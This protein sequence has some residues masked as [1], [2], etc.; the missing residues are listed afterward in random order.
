MG[1]GHGITDSPL[2]NEDLA[3]VSAANRSWSLWNIAALWVGMA[4]CIP[5][6]TLAAGLIS[7]G[8]SWKQAL[9]TIALGNLI[10][11]LPMMLN[12]HAGTRYGI[13]FPVLLRASFGTVGAN[14][15]AMMRALV[16]CG[17]FGIQTWIGGSAIYTLTL[18]ILGNEPA[19]PAQMLP[20]L[21]LSWGQLFGFLAFWA[22][23]IAVIV[24]G[25]DT[26]KRLETFAAPFLLLI[27]A[28]LLIWGIR[29]AGGLDVVLAADTVARV[30]GEL[31][32]GF[33]FWRAFWPNLTAMVGFWAT[34]SLN[35][36]DFS[37]YARSQ[38]DQMLGQLI[39]LPTTMAFYSFIGIAVTCA[40][41]VIFG[42]AIWDPVQLLG[43]FDNKLTVAFALFA[44][45]V[46]TL[47]TNIAANV[48]SPAN[49]FANLRPRSISFRRG[50]LITGTI[51]ILIMPWKL[52][53]DLS[54]YI[55]TWLIGY[56]AMLGSIAGVMLVDYFILRRRRLAVADLYAVD[57]AYSYR[58][59]VNW[60][61]IVA[62]AVGI[63]F[64]AP[65]FLA[66]VSG[67]SIAVPS[68]FAQLY[69]YAWFVGL[70]LSGLVFLALGSSSP[71]STKEVAS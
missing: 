2:Y 61:A 62:V 15:P 27:G 53:T 19:G 55:F 10:V 49:D 25:I 17:W 65:G 12:A 59:G 44:L 50:G 4:V 21:G 31:P 24:R 3:P 8:M 16:A 14:I 46:A 26:I 70:A 67:G 43:R 66:Q 6:Y 54:N 34:L 22:I 39:G 1:L 56:S 32:G 52:Y 7:Q 35:I 47:S 11:L 18:V 40:T 63:G 30:R 13:P 36:P 33:D 68:F 38:R 57:G 41:V 71:Q 37:R 5:T 64:N 51:G 23:N 20:V 42:E 69:T 9:L 58:G 29:G 45:T 28:G 48:V 60:R